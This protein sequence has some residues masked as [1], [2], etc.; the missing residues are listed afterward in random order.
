MRAFA[1]DTASRPMT[2]PEDDRRAAP[3]S[4]GDPPGQLSSRGSAHDDLLVRPAV[5]ADEAQILALAERT[6]GWGSED[7]WTELF[8][9]KHDLNAFGRSPRWVATIDERVVGFRVFLRW[10]FTGPGGRIQRAV[11]AVD[12]ATDPARQGRGIFKRLTTTAVG[13]LTAEGTDFVFNTPNDQSRPGYLKMGW[14]I[15]GRPPI[16]TL[17]TGLGGAVRQTNA[18]TAAE[19]WSLPTVAGSDAREALSAPRIEDLLNALDPISRMST[20]RTAEYL[21]WRY[22]LAEL[23]YRA[24]ALGDDP[25]EGLVVFRLRRR[26]RALEG[27]VCELLV[28]AGRD[29]TRRKRRL[30]RMVARN[31]AADYLLVGHDRGLIR[32]PALPVPRLGP[33]LTWR[34][35]E[36]QAEPRL[37]DFRLTMGDLELF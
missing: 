33:I 28:P 22:G 25:A 36:A 3:S 21:R 20:H 15:V 11:R 12:T 24:I 10:E 32:T 7:R 14:Q 17:P 31:S 16:M 6:L 5:V 8:R 29:A 2:E 34:G 37:Q 9:W 35:L 30:L 27:T 23:H 18:R 4:P 1:R 13:D 19:L 26:G